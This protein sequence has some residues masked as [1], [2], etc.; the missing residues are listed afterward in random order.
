MLTDLHLQKY[1][2]GELSE[3]EERDVEAMVEKNPELKARLEALENKS[4]VMGKPTWQRMREHRHA[5][6]GSR[7]RYTIMLPALLILVVILMVSQ[8]WF[9]K[10]GQNSTFT[11]TGGNG[12]AIEL[13]Y[14]SKNGWRYVDADYK[15]SDSLSFAVRDAGSYHVAVTAVYGNPKGVALGSNPGAEVVPLW[16]DAPDRTYAQNG[17]KPV[18]TA[19]PGRL[20]APTQIIVFYR[21]TPLPEVGGAGAIEL[22]EAR[23]IERGGGDVQYQVFS[24]A[25]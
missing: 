16:P 20:E 17:S 5:R 14:N 24:F 3:E 13:L 1:L 10:P 21:D 8:H 23:G 11:M 22:M 25:P 15:P 2:D 9:S 4:Q 6:K 7:T 18:F 12:K 19:P